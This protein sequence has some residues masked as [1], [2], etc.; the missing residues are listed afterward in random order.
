MQPPALAPARAWAGEVAPG[1]EPGTCREVACSRGP[2]Q[3]RGTSG[4]VL[5]ASRAKLGPRLPVI[6]IAP[7]Q[8]QRRRAIASSSRL[9]LQSSARHAGWYVPHQQAEPHLPMRLSLHR[10]GTRRR[11]GQVSAQSL[12]PSS[13]RNRHTRMGPREP[14]RT[15]ATDRWHGTALPSAWPDE[16]TSLAATVQPLR[17]LHEPQGAIPSPAVAVASSAAG[18]ESSLPSSSPPAPPASASDSPAPLSS[19]MLA[20]ACFLASARKSYCLWTRV[21]ST[22]S[23]GMPADSGS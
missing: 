23:D 3:A 7:W 14:R 13:S 17:L 11:S 2:R 16:A 5:L 20:S 9:L 21:S 6:K 22:R 12:R 4:L 19:D 18:K 15:T 10:P 8:L 1:L